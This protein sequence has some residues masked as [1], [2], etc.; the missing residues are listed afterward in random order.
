MQQRS[1]EHYKSSESCEQNGGYSPA[2]A[3][4][5][6]P[7]ATATSPKLAN[8]SVVATVPTNMANMTPASCI[9]LE[10]AC[11]GMGAYPI[12]D[13]QGHTIRKIS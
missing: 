8:V 7:P 13:T 1:K 12:V 2:A 3:V 11:S 4:V 5:P 6:A 10:E 9:D